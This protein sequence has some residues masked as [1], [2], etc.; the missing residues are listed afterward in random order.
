LQLAA[1]SLQLAACSLQLAACSL[2]LAVVL[3]GGFPY[4]SIATAFGPVFKMQVWSGN[5]TGCTYFAYF[6]T[7][8]H[9]VA[10]AYRAN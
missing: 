7:S 1:C 10:G 6:L 9:F 3:P 5:I 8:N 2:Q 4:L